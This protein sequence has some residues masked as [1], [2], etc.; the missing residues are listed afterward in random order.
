MLFFLE[1][2]RNETYKKRENII[3][4]IATKKYQDIL[5]DMADS[6]DSDLEPDRRY[7]LFCELRNSVSHF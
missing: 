3:S 5:S 6:I 2:Y 4:L 7:S 1:W